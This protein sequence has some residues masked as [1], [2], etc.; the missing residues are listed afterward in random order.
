MKKIL[1]M[2]MLVLGMAS[3][4]SPIEEND[5]MGSILQESELQVDVH[6][7]TPGSNKIV[8]ENNTKGVGNYWDYIIGKSTRQ[9]DTILLPFLGKQKITFTAICAGGTVQTTREVDINKID[10]PL[11]SIWNLLA[12]SDENGKTW[13]WATGNPTSGYTDGTSCLFGNGGTTDITPAWWQVEA[14]EMN[15]SWKLLYDEMTFDLNGGAHFTLISRGKDGTEKNEVTKDNFILNVDKKT[16]K[17]ANGTPFILS[18][19]FAKGEYTIAKLTKDELVLVFTYQ[20]S[21]NYVW[22]FKRKGYTY[23]VV[24]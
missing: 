6:S 18:Q 7:I 20:N 1:L 8:L 21:E 19:D 17:T 11:D 23:P 24:H 5:S 10:Y 15:N 14:N 12:G 13:V 4:L 3:C 2:A 16:I 9:N 22:M